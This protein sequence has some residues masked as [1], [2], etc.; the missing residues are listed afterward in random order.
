MGK[1]LLYVAGEKTI[2]SHLNTAILL[3]LLFVPRETFAQTVEGEK[4]P[5]LSSENGSL[6]TEQDCPVEPQSLI[7]AQ[8]TQGVENE[9][10]LKKQ[11]DISLQEGIK[12]VFAKD[13]GDKFQP[14]NEGQT[15]TD[16]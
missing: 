6:E 2:S 14:K 10:I 13:H 8:L 12:D 15:N 4:K 16:N 1:Q 3:V 7:S 11:G 9:L 5:K